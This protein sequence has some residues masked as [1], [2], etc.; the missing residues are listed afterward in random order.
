[1]TLGIYP[2]LTVDQARRA[3]QP[4]VADL[5]RGGDPNAEKRAAIEARRRVEHEAVTV[6]VLWER[7]L[8]EDVATHNKA[9]TAEMKLRLWERNIE[10]VIGK[11]A[12]AGRH[13]PASFERLVQGALRV[14]AKRQCHRRQGG[15]GQSLSTAAPHVREGLAW[16]LRPLELGHP[17]DG[18][19]QPRVPRRERLL[20]MTSDRLSRRDRR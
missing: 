20:S 8:R 12:G 13:R 4:V 11:I 7:Y 10:P 15:R 3:S 2:D 9:S 1:M 5:V 18:M 6:T 14:D 17:L 16:R 19:E